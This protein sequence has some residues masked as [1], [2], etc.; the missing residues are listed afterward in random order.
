MIKAKILLF[1]FLSLLCLSVISKVQACSHGDCVSAQC[2]VCD[3]LAGCC[4]GDCCSPGGGGGGIPPDGQGQCS[5]N[6][7]AGLCNAITP[8]NNINHAESSLKGLCGTYDIKSS[9][10]PIIWSWPTPSK[11]HLQVLDN[12]KNWLF[13]GW[14]KSNAYI[15]HPK[16]TK[17]K[18]FSARISFDGKTFLPTGVVSCP[19]R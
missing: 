11:V 15:V 6:P 18:V 8:K 10:T 5:N 14:I 3:A 16:D 12:K 7:S 9:T 2:N 4:G 19:S 17:G 13:N 1:V